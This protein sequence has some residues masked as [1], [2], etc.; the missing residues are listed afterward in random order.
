MI[1]LKINTFVSISMGLVVEGQLNSHQ[2]IINILRRNLD[3]T[4]YCRI[5]SY[6]MGYQ[7]S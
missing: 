4:A 6:L 2:A 5:V 3:A 1:A 7:Q